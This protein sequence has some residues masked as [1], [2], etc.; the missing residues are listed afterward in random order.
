[1]VPIVCESK[2]GF[3]ICC[4]SGDNML[5]LHCAS[6]VPFCCLYTPFTI[7]CPLT[8]NSSCHILPSCFGTSQ[9]HDIA[10]LHDILSCT[11]PAHP[12]PGNVS[13][14]Y[15]FENWPVLDKNGFSAFVLLHVS[16]DCMEPFASNLH[17][18]EFFPLMAKVLGS[19]QPTNDTALRSAW[20]W[21]LPHIFWWLVIRLCIHLVSGTV[22]LASFFPRSKAINLFFIF[23]FLRK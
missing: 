10:A 19:L 15:T 4:V 20:Q 23:F 16:F 1:M 18:E 6:D 5:R 12:L 8:N 9:I 7:S 3:L 11:Y 2:E 14:H 21:L 22:I 17:F 13:C